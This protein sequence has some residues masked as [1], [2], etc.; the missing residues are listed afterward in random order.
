[1][2]RLL[3]VPALLATSY[4]LACDCATLPLAQRMSSSTDVIVGEVV[5]HVALGSVELRVLER[6]KG[7]SASPITIVTGQSDCDFFLPP[8][9]A[10]PGEKYLLFLTKSESRI[11]ANRCL[12]SALVSAASDQLKTLRSIAT[13]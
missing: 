7:D 5:R 11:T 1:V 9:T 13:K 8:T 2:R 10:R 6:F 4:A 12:G 3:L